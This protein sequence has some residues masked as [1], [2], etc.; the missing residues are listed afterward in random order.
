MGKKINKQQLRQIIKEEAMKL[1]RRVLLEAE[2]KQLMD[3][4]KTLREYYDPKVDGPDAN[5]HSKFSYS[6]KISK[7]D[8]WEKLKQMIKINP[9]VF[10][11]WSNFK[12]DDASRSVIFAPKSEEL[13]KYSFSIDNVKSSVDLMK[14]LSQ[15][16]AEFASEASKKWD[17]SKKIHDGE[18]RDKIIKLSNTDPEKATKFIKQLMADAKRLNDEGNVLAKLSN[19]Y[20]ASG[21]VHD[22][23]TKVKSSMNND[24]MD[25]SAKG[26][27]KYVDAAAMGYDPD[28]YVMYS[29]MDDYDDYG[30]YD[31]PYVSHRTQSFNDR[32]DVAAEKLASGEWD[33]EQAAEFRA[34]A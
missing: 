19:P 4:L 17:E 25:A 28:E 22:A 2:K 24:F 32:S 5:P 16:A 12:I 6:D 29:A 15:K 27:E 18:N 14:R 30:D 10:S 33:E 34:G 11:E 23:I 26:N 13:K 8:D 31:E 1:N 21:I 3:E 20:S 7:M 9:G